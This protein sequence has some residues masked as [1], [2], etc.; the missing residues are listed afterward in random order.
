MKLEIP[1]H[2]NQIY[3]LVK[4]KYEKMPDIEVTQLY[5]T[6]PHMRDEILAYVICKN[7]PL[8]AKIG[9]KYYYPQ[10]LDHQE[11]HMTVLIDT[12]YKYLP[13]YNGTTKLITYLGSR[14]KAELLNKFARLRSKSA[15]LGLHP[16]VCSK[17]S[18]NF[19]VSGKGKRKDAE[20]L[21]CLASTEPCMEEMEQRLELEGII[22]EYLNSRATTPANKELIQ[23]MADGYS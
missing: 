19:I 17:A 7:A 23:L 1:H 14:Y 16:E 15:D 11:M 2:F 5:S 10:F 12:V 13:Q 21:E 3:E 4:E 9:R 20:F 22:E 8:F 18:I 6:A